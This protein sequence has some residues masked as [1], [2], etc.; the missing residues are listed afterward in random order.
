MI[1]ALAGAQAGGQQDRHAD[2]VELVDTPSG[3][4][5]GESRVSSSLTVGTMIHNRAA[6]PAGGGA[7][8]EQGERSMVERGKQVRVRARAPSF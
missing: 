5:G 1:L 2:V 4:G 3:G 7:A 8:F 6:T